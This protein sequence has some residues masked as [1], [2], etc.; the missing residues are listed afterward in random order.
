M[1]REKATSVKLKVW[2]GTLRKNCPH[3]SVRGIH[4]HDELV[5]RA[6]LYQNGSGGEKF[7][8]L[9]KGA[10]SFRGLGEMG[11]WER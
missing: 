1:L 3:P 8:Q 2:Y 10:V 9:G 5:D 7:L 4:L 11:S 6:R